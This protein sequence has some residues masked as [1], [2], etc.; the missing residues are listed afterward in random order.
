M[1]EDSLLFPAPDPG[2]A[3]SAPARARSEG[4]ELNLLPDASFDRP[5]VDEARGG[6]V[7]E[8]EALAGEEGDVLGALTP[9]YLP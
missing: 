4:L 8:G 2:T 1:V 9:L 6:Q 5:V 7:F 3:R